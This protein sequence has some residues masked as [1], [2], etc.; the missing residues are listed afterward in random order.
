[1][2]REKEASFVGLKERALAAGTLDDLATSLHDLVRLM[3]DYRTSAPTVACFEALDAVQARL[4]SH[5]EFPHD[6]ESVESFSALLTKTISAP[7]QIMTAQLQAQHK[8]LQ[9]LTK[10]ID[11]VKTS[12]VSSGPCNHAPTGSSTPAPTKPKVTPLTN[13]PDERIL[14]WCDSDPPLLFSAP[15][16]ELVP[17]L[18]AHLTTLDL[19]TIL[20]ASR[21]KDGGLFLVPGSKEAVILLGKEWDRWGPS[22]LPGARIIPPAVYSHIQID[23]IPHAAAPDLE[24]LAKELSERYPE[25]GPVV[26][27][28]TWVNAPPSDAQISATLAAGKKPRT[29][30]SVM[31]RLSFQAKVDVAISLG[32]LRLAGSAP[33]VVCGFPHLRVSQCWG[34]YKFGHIKARCT[35]KIPKCGGCG[36]AAHGTTCVTKP[37][38]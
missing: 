8:A 36:N 1:M 23:G 35:V 7:V 32:R 11:A 34:C 4:D 17:V 2:S 26:G 5:H 10:S 16:H 22:V 31:L 38:V 24:A 29:A 30:G 3:R 37:N 13:T 28:P 21:S 19:P 33:T 14:L 12:H 18:N 25:L 9:M 15:Y 27:K 20:C 6:A